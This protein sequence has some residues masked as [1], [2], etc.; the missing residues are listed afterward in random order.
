MVFCFYRRLSGRLPDPPKAENAIKTSGFF[1]YFRWRLGSIWGSFRAPKEHQ[2]Y[3]FGAYLGLFRDSSG[4][5][6]SLSA[7]FLIKSGPVS[8][9]FKFQR[10]VPADSFQ[11]PGGSLPVPSGSI[12]FLGYPC[13]LIIR[14]QW[15]RRYRE[16]SSIDQL[17][18]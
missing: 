2:N 9:K 4:L 5:D 3:P 7:T 18:D 11:F 13:I 8:I 12:W 16:A 6:S 17:K 1:N 14:L 15:M 10:P